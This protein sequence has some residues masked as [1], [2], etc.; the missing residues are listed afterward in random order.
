[1][2]KQI[3][4][5]TK[6]PI[7][8]ETANLDEAEYVA[9]KIRSRK[10]YYNFVDITIIPTT[11]SMTTVHYHESVPNFTRKDIEMYMSLV[12]GNKKLLHNNCIEYRSGK[13]TINM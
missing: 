1:M 8:I 2:N 13:R 6:Q 11:E 3:W 12:F 9:N 7:I 10:G 4:T 5:N